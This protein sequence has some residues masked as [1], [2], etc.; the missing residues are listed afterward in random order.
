MQ[1]ELLPVIDIMLDLYEKPRTA[2]RFQEYLEVLQGGTKGDLVIPIGNF[3][4]MAKEQALQKLIEL[5]TLHAEYDQH[6]PHEP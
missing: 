6:E 1:F 2:E 3:N 4:P 5:K